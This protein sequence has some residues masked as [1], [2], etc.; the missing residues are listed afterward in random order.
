MKTTEFA[1]VVEAFGR[2]HPKHELVVAHLDD[3][4]NM[5]DVD[6]SGETPSLTLTKSLAQRVADHMGDGWDAASVAAVLA[7]SSISIRPE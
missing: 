3:V 6:W 1:V 5:E 7:G 4:V 2:M